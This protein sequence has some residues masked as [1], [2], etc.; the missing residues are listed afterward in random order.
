M[1][2]V[3]SPKLIPLFHYDNKSM[4]LNK[5]DKKGLL[6]YQGICIFYQSKYHPEHNKH[7]IIFTQIR[8]K[9]LRAEKLGD[10]TKPWKEMKHSKMGFSFCK[11]VREDTSCPL[12]VGEIHPYIEA[13]SPKYYTKRPDA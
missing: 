8:V 9:K 12:E 13:P 11:S 4:P 10:G 6:L 7:W 3:P 5:A 1:K 2:D